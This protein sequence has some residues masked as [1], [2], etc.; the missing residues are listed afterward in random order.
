MVRSFGGCPTSVA[1]LRHDRRPLQ[2]AIFSVSVL[3]KLQVIRRLSQKF[4]F[5]GR[6]LRAIAVQFLSSQAHA[7]AA[8]FFIISLVLF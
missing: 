5:G 1:Q 6:D 2:Q 3:T 7:G 8:S 4:T